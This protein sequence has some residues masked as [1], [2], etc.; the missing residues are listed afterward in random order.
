ML[1][2][3]YSTVDAMVIK[4]HANKLYTIGDAYVISCVKSHDEFPAVTALRLAIEIR[5][6]VVKMNLD[7]KRLKSDTN[8]NM[9]IRIGISGGPMVFGLIGYN[10]NGQRPS[11]L[12]WGPVMSGRSAWNR[13]QFP[14]EY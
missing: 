2:Q 6:S 9:S 1:H 8:T 12:V 4:R 13:A 5:D 7:N 3:L 10:V 14:T 11:Y